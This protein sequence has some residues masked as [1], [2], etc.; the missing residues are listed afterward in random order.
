MYSVA[1]ST[2]V[3]LF[4]SSHPIHMHASQAASHLTR[5]THVIQA[6]FLQRKMSCCACSASCLSMPTQLHPWCKRAWLAITSG[7][8]LLCRLNN[9]SLVLF[10]EIIPTLIYMWLLLAISR[11]VSLFAQYHN[12]VHF[13]S[14]IQWIT[15]PFSS[16]P[17]YS[18]QNGIVSSW[19]WCHERKPL[20]CSTK[21]INKF[22]ENSSFSTFMYMFLKA[23][24][25]W[26]E[27]FGWR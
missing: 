8:W 4:N 15:P 19:E 17:S 24:P 18:D 3:P 12:F 7:S 23:V 21:R 26:S 27:Y 25:M 5:C 16:V 14:V 13:F 11:H 6:H 10:L 9:M 1:T 22:T 2:L 20:R